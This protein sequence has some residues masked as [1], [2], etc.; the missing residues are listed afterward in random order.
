MSLIGK[1]GE[2]Y[3]LGADLLR[4]ELIL[5]RTMRPHNDHAGQ[6]ARDDLEGKRMQMRDKRDKLGMLRKGAFYTGY[7]AHSCVEFYQRIR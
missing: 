3:G 2:A 1:F 6:K 4:T 5:D 7:F